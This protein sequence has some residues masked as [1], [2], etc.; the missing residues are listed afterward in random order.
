MLLK[1][2]KSAQYF[3]HGEYHQVE[4]NDHT[5]VV[6]SNLAEEHI[7]FLVW[8]GAVSV[9]RGIC[10]GELEFYSHTDDGQRTSWLIQGLPWEECTDF[11]NYAI[12]KYQQWHG[13]QCETLA[14][15]LPEWLCDLNKLINYDGYLPHSLI[16]QW[17]E[18]VAKG[19]NQLSI[20]MKQLTQRL[21]QLSGMISDWYDETGEQEEERNQIWLDEEKKRWNVLF[22]QVESSP[23]NESQQKA[24]LIND[25]HNLVL[26]GAGSG[27]TSVLI[28]RV[29]YLIESGLAQANEILMLAFGRG[30][31]IE[32]EE[33]LRSRIGPAAKDITVCTFHQL[34]L[35]ILKTGNE[36]SVTISSLAT[37]EDKKMEWCTDWLKKHW[38]TPT[39][40][41]RWHKHLSQ[42][43]IAY[44]TG[45]D[46]LG[47]HVEDSKLISWLVKQIDTLSML[48]LSKKD[49]QKL[50]V[51]NEDY[52]RLNSELML[53]WPCY[54]S[55]NRLLKESNEVDFNLMISN[56]I[57]VVKKKAFSSPWKHIMIDEYQDISSDRLLLIEL[58]CLS[59]KFNDRT[60]LYAVGDD[61][62]SIY[63]FAGS[64][65]DLTI[66]FQHR[67]PNSVITYLDTTYRFNN[68]IGKVAN[69]FIQQNPEQLPKS[70]S[71]HI[72]V[73]R[74]RVFLLNQTRIE[75]ILD[76][77]NRE[78]KERKSLILLGRNHYHEPELLEDWQKR[79]G[80]LMIR[81]MTCHASKGKE[82]DYVII[83]NV[84]EGQFPAKMKRQHL[85]S[86]LTNKKEVFPNAQE[87][88]L[89][90]VAMTRAKEKL[91]IAYSGKGS[92]FIE[93]LQQSSYP[94]KT[95]K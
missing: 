46:E 36:S 25:D 75:K 86:V 22:S 16:F 1:A 43:P 92:S 6:S 21:P 55:W 23:L 29:A 67:F 30:A 27:K 56:A 72:T 70:L 76:S 12:E 81:F 85:N 31:A 88:R 58:L 41:K 79:F 44:I 66:D 63:E 73:K 95:I 48:N 68:M 51:E 93:E 15:V 7:S 5:L 65:V 28:A 74:P 35:N 50:I 10:W 91:W 80:H 19:L 64:D 90:Y 26:A 9:R 62:Q 82:A 89:F 13:E 32:M 14:T 17:K 11:A 20:S 2:S 42:W 94:I 38:M 37:N 57:N 34:G 24:V 45:D 18:E 39:H 49:I 40:Y 54:Q 77:L 59:H 53:V 71:S 84:D 69:Q 60:H 8:N 33:R 3:I 83:L 61:W 87:R 78:V 4:L 47:S 52:S